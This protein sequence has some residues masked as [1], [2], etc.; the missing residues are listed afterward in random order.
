MAKKETIYKCQQCGTEHLKWTGKCQECGAWNSLQEV[1][2]ETTSSSS[3]GP[4]K[5]KGKKVALQKF[6]QVKSKKTDRI[7]TKIGELDRVLGGGIVPGSLVLVAGEPGIGKSTLLTQLTLKLTGTKNLEPKTKGKSK[8]S[9]GSIIYICGEESPSQVKLRIKRLSQ[10]SKFQVQG[11]NLLFL[12]ETNIENI[13]TTINQ[14][15][16]QQLIIVD[17]IQSLWTSNLTGSAG[18][19]GQVRHC[20]NMLLNLSKKTNIPIFIIGHVTKEGSIAGP[21]VLE[22]LVDTVLYIEGD[23]Q[24]FFRILRASKNRFG[25]VDEVGVFS[26]G[27]KGME[28]VKNPSD[29]FLEHKDKRKRAKPGSAIVSTIQGLRPMLV[30]IQALV[31]PSKLAVPRRVASGINHKKLQ[32]LCAVLQ[33]RLNFN[34]ATR[35]VFVSVAGG[36]KLDE[37]AVD[38]GICAAIV[39]SYKNKPLPKTAV[40]IGEVGLLGEIRKVS[41]MKKRIKQAKK[42]GYKTII[43]Q[44]EKSINQVLK[45]LQ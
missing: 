7:K 4:K 8:K 6:S 19:V 16:N 1:A 21:K 13:L 24:H 12:P 9:P 43:G 23:R 2:E 5:A 18:T 14:Q 20:A 36:I 11:S 35:D 22:H 30:E 39:S 44:K 34:I 38:L 27:D 42:L 32:V 37:P 15:P 17:S 10:S 31:I 33:K 29:V 41:F 45:Y 26:M 3:F 28:E 40:S 25:P